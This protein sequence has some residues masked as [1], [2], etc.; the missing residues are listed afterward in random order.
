[1]SRTDTYRCLSASYPC[2]HSPLEGRSNM[3]SAVEEEGVGSKAANSK[4]DRV[5]NITDSLREWDS[6]GDG[7]GHNKNP[8]F[9][10]TS[11]VNGT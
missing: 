1:M 11:Y 6:D 2:A 9:Q 3:T 8:K 4:D 5:A 10:Q 7:G